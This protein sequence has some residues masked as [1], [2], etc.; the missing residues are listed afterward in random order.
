MMKRHK[1]KLYFS[2]I[3]TV[4]EFSIQVDGCTHGRFPFY[5]LSDITQSGARLRFWTQQRVAILC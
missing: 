4:L 5:N 1:D 3:P 2:S